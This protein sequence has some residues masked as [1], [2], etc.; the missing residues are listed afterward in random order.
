M[1]SMEHSQQ[2][3]IFQ[4][5]S[6]KCLDGIQ[7]TDDDRQ[8][9]DERFAQGEWQELGTWIIAKFPLNNNF[10]HMYTCCNFKLNKRNNI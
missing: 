10:N 9:A 7:I 8:A 1:A 4:L 5:R 6:L 2:F 3:V